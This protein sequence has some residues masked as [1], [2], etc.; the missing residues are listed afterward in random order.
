MWGT[1]GA[2]D[3]YRRGEPAFG[4]VPRRAA[5][6]RS[7]IWAEARRRLGA[8]VERCAGTTCRSRVLVW[9]RRGLTYHLFVSS[10]IRYVK[11]LARA[12]DDDDYLTAA[13][14]M[15]ERV[16][17][18]IGDLLIQGPQAVVA[19]YRAASEMARRLFDQVGYGHEVAPTDDPYSFRISYSDV[20]TVG[21]ESLTHTAE[22]HVTVA[23]DE[24]VVRIINVDLPGEREKV[25]WFLARHGLERDR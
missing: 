2:R 24:G 15:A 22:Q 9:G 18:T 20:L 3:D 1:R 7:Q 21:D 25:D 8:I 23:P 11:A 17:Y 19:S 5:L 13:S 12:L 10:P 14:T 6:A 4:T 16:E